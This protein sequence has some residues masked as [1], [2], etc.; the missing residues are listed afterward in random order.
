MINECWSPWSH[1]L[2]FQKSTS[3]TDDLASSPLEAS[4]SGSPLCFVPG[5]LSSSS[6]LLPQAHPAPRLPRALPGEGKPPSFHLP[7]GGLWWS[8]I[9]LSTFQK[10][11]QRLTEV[12]VSCNL[13]LGLAI[14]HPGSDGSK[15]WDFCSHRLPASLWP[16]GRLEGDGVRKYVGLLTR[17]LT[18]TL[19]LVLSW[20]AGAL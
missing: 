1:C 16:S 19:Q 7:A 17:R 10:R 2:F 8:S 5:W 4:S 11:K 6:H 20:I 13:A 14:H 18:L 12:K 9:T 3:G 15:C